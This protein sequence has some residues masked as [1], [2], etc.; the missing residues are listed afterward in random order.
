M[1]ISVQITRQ[2]NADHF[3]AS[4]GDTVSVEFEEYVA[5]VVASE[6]GNSL[7]ETCKAQAIAARSFAI[8][9]GVLRGR[10]ISDSSATAQ[11][12]RAGRYDK[13]RYPNAVSGTE[14]TAGKV[15]VYKGE[16][17]SAVYTAGNGGR[18]VSS[19]E[20]WGGVRPYLIAQDDPW[21]AL[22]G[23]SKSGHGVGMSQRGAIQA[24]KLGKG[25]EEILSF[26][27]PGTVVRDNYNKTET[28]GGDA[29]L[30]NEKATAVR[31]LA[32]SKLGDPYVYGARG[33]ECTP[34]IRKQYASY[35]PQYK[36]NIYRSCPVLS[37]T[38]SNCT[39]CKWDGHLCYD[40]RGFTYYCLLSG[41]GIKLEGGGATSQYNTASNWVQ[42]GTIEN[43]PNVVCCVFKKKE[44]KMSHTGLHEG[45]G[46]LIHC[47][48]T[49]KR[50]E[51]TDSGW[52]HYAVPKGLYTE[53]ELEEAG[54][55]IVH[56]TLKKG[57]RGESVKELQEQLNSLGYDCGTA[58]G[59]FGNKTDV[60]VRYFQTDNGLKADG[61]VGGQTW[62]ALD[63]KETGQISSETQEVE[64]LTTE[65]ETT[66]NAEE[67]NT[68]TMD[69]YKTICDR[70]DALEYMLDDIMKQ[71]KEIQL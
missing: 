13:V 34:R 68:M 58:D 27:Y 2:E 39:G 71:I 26:Y 25:Y 63:A 8:S 41:A 12:Y 16:V 20:Q 33:E 35:N 19:E 4:I 1:D 14:E 17:I 67:N 59:I 7:V 15:L 60:A 62:A 18:T 23:R 56:P 61:I 47:S 51:S 52:T 24:A 28:K 57:S 69:Q 70:L 29:V 5:A 3:G 45:D 42:R 53:K 22:D 50:G 40:C 66:K 21:D 44:D 38:Q 48:T 54:L 31:D 49:V 32:E 55:V 46:K 37:G 30:L 9:R 10:S 64:E 36:D 65:E 11:A 43:M 6:V